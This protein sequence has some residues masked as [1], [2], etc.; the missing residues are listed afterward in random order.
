MNIRYG[1]HSSL[2]GS[3]LALLAH[4]YRAQLTKERADSK[5]KAVESAD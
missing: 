3:L 5:S 2:L 4:L 1:D